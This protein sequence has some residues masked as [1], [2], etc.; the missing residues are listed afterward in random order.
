ME[1]I[2]ESDLDLK[3]KIVNNIEGGL[4]EKEKPFSANVEKEVSQEIVAA[5]KDD[6]YGRIL[7]KVQAQ[8]IDEVD[9]DAVAGD[10]EIGSKQ[11]DAESQVQHLI[12]IAGQKGVV[13]AVKV[14]Q[15]MEDNYTLDTFHD[16][17]LSDEF[18]DALVKKGMIKEL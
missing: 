17:M 7:S 11:I 16:R 8:A 15:H 12:D 10:A 18:H 3:A 2:E 1:P 6:S 4:P 13:H 9:Q 5:E 14:A